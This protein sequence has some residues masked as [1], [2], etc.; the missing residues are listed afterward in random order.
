M[1]VAI[2][3][4]HSPYCFNV[5]LNRKNDGSLRFCID[6]RKLNNSTIKDADMLP[7]VNDSLDSLLGS[8]Y[9]TKLDL[10]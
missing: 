3:K 5:V 4:S 8:K 10:R 2:R 1:L 9:F 6:L 7:R